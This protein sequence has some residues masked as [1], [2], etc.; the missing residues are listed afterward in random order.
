[1]AVMTVLGHMAI[2]KELWYSESTNSDT[3]QTYQY[4]FELRNRI[5]DTCKVARDK[6]ETSQFRYNGH[7]DKKTRMRTLNIGDQV[8]VML[9]TD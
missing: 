4:I 5:E 7:F 8:L 6:L 3:R 9:P 2:L 1:M